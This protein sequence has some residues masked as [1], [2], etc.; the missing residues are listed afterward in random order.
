MATLNQWKPTT[1]VTKDKCLRLLVSRGPQL[2]DA[3]APCDHRSAAERAKVWRLEL[4]ESCVHSGIYNP[5]DLHRL[6]GICIGLKTWRTRAVTGDINSPR[7]RDKKKGWMSG[8]QYWTI[9]AN[10][11]GRSVRRSSERPLPGVSW[12]VAC[13]NRLGRHSR[14]SISSLARPEKNEGITCLTNSNGFE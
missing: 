8:I 9:Q 10:E 1:V 7:L 3:I 4:G 13:W 6:E 12:R 11:S 5:R 14:G 2:L